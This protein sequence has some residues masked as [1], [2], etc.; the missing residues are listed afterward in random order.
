LQP[1][2]NL[3]VWQPECQHARLISLKKLSEIS[4]KMLLL[5]ICQTFL[6]NFVQ[7]LHR[8]H[9]P[10]LFP[11]PPAIWFYPLTILLILCQPYYQHTQL[12]NLKQ[13][14]EISSKMHLLLSC[15]TFSFGCKELSKFHP[16]L[17]VFL[18]NL[19]LLN[20]CSLS[21]I[22]QMLSHNS[23]PSKQILLLL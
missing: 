11:H 9:L 5:F 20:N 14:E 2:K 15:Q 10:L 7:P 23:C 4:L 16:N 12:V 1:L 13:L 17:L 22:I 21:R 18:R 6:L 8:I 3:F 19:L